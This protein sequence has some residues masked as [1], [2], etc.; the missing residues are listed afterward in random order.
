[1]YE[2]HGSHDQKPI[3]DTLRK[4][5]ITLKPSNHKEREQKKEQIT[6]K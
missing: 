1:M 2:Y 3:K 4:S 5:S 6:T